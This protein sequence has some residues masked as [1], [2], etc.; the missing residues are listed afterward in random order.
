MAIAI[1][2]TNCFLRASTNT[3]SKQL[4]TSVSLFCIGATFAAAIAFWCGKTHALF[5][6]ACFDFSAT[7]LQEHAPT[8]FLVSATGAYLT[9]ILDS[10]HKIVRMIIIIQALPELRGI[11]FANYLSRMRDALLI[12]R[13]AVANIHRNNFFVEKNCKA[14]LWDTSASH[15]FALLHW[16]WRGGIRAR[17]SEFLSDDGRQHESKDCC[18]NSKSL[19]RHVSCFLKNTSR[20]EK[21][22][23]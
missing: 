17:S 11:R 14:I 16:G 6:W 3:W 20:I 22:L 18:D 21:T 19:P 2:I 15:T 10:N 9:S 23:T 4:R 8:F 5:A 13:L 12:I 1:T 7:D